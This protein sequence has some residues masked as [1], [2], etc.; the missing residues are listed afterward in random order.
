MVCCVSVLTNDHDG[1]HCGCP[2]GSIKLM[3]WY[4]VSVLN[5][6]HDGVH[7]GCPGD[8]IKLMVWYVV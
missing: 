1:V 4:V 5:N 6:D 8:Y 7:C 3:V 2:G